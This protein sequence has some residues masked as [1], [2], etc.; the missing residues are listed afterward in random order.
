M[1]NV[2]IEYIDIDYPDVCAECNTICEG[3][4]VK[5]DDLGTYCAYNDNGQLYGCYYQVIDEC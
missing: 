4:A 1:H 3:N 5:I 2:N